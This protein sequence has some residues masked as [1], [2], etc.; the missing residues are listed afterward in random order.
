MI[1]RDR[2]EKNELHLLTR[3]FKMYNRSTNGYVSGTYK[4]L[5]RV[6]FV[7]GANQFK[8]GFLSIFWHADPTFEAFNYLVIYIQSS[9]HVLRIQRLMQISSVPN[10][11]SIT[12][13]SSVLCERT[14]SKEVKSLSIGDIPTVFFSEKGRVGSDFVS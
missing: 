4:H 10:K 13:A 8:P 5:Q 12:S 3:T 2:V 1:W 9:R 6:H 7:N 14:N 11:R